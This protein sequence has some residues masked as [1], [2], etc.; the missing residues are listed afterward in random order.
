M[1]KSFI[2]NLKDLKKKGIICPVG[3]GDETYSILIE[4][5]KLSKNNTATSNVYFAYTFKKD[6][7]KIAFHGN[8]LPF[9]PN[10][11]F[12]GDASLEL[13][14]PFKIKLNNDI[15]IRFKNGTKLTY[16]C[17]GF[18]NVDAKIDLIF[19]NK[20]IAVDKEY[21]PIQNQNVTISADISFTN[22]EDFLVQL[23]INKSFMIKG[24]KD[25]V[26]NLKKTIVDMSDERTPEISFPQNYESSDFIEGNKNQWKGLYIKSASIVLPKQLHKKHT[27]TSK[28]E[29]IKGL[30]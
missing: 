13:V 29:K 5:I 6:N 7:T 30:S 9:K 28:K 22:F 2:K 23:D 19:S 11:G 18:K 3:I 16:N 14:A 25:I 26:F 21:K 24:I 10:G 4:Q 20:F 1:T 8:E 17:N 15:A 27:K 12:G